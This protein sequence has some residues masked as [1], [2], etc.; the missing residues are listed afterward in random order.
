MPQEQDSQEMIGNTGV[1][2]ISP[3]AQGG[4]QKQG[5]ES[6]F[7]YQQAMTPEAELKQLLHFI[8]DNTGLEEYFGI[9][10]KQGVLSNLTE[11]D[12]KVI[13]R[14]VNLI[15]LWARMGR[16]RWSTTFND[17]SREAQIKV[18][19]FKQHRRSRGGFERM[20]LV[21][22]KVE[23]KANVVSI[24]GEARRKRRFKVW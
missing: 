4:Q 3:L 9:F 14:R 15:L 21:T 6:A 2:L 20:A 13:D 19:S 17:L 16:P 23:Q 8:Y 12:I 24:A 18:K 10:D 11:E 22:Q 7:D 1:P 5:P